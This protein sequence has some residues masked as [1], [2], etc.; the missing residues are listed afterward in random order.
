MKTKH[1]ANLCLAVVGLAVGVNAGCAEN[2]KPKVEAS[3]S[4]ENQT[5]WA[6]IKDHTFAQRESFFVGLRYLEA[7]VDAQIAEL[8]AK[9]AI[10]NG[11]T[12]TKD[13]DFAMKEMSDARTYLKSMGEELSKATPESW[14]QQKDKVGQAWV[15]TQTA[16]ANVKAST[17]S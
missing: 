15:R 6:D 2:E 11:K 12:D 1:Y 10:M 5:R 16:Y 4:T 3:N 14:S 8:A 9:R 13:W 17:T 7:R